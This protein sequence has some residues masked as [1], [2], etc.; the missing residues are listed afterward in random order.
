MADAGLNHD[1][2]FSSPID[3][4]KISLYIEVLEHNGVRLSTMYAQREGKEEKLFDRIGFPKELVEGAGH[5]V[6]CKTAR[7]Y[8][9]NVIGI[10]PILADRLLGDWSR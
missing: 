9:E 8:M 5:L 3:E 4:P 1:L 6:Y 7:D 10:S 2:G